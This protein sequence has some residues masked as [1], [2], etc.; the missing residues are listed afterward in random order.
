[1]W[2]TPALPIRDEMAQKVMFKKLPKLFEQ[3]R[4]LMDA[5]AELRKRR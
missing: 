4:E 1:V 5:V 3:V 2:G